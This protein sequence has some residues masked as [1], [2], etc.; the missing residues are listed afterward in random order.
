MSRFR[1][2][3]AP[4]VVGLALLLIWEGFITLFDVDEFLLPRPSSIASALRDQWT[5]LR[6]AGWETGKI[7][8]S[9][10]VI[11]VL[12]GGALALAITRFRGLA[13]SVTPVAVAINA[14]PI[15]A[16]APVFNA[17]FGSTDPRS[18]QAVVVVVVFFP[19]FINTARGLLEV[20]ANQ[21]ELMRSYAA[22]EWTVLR[23]VR[24]PNALP[25]FLTSLRVAA[26]LSVIAAIV[27]EYFGGPQDR[28][29]PF[30]T[31]NAAFSRYANAWA[32]IVVASV[33]GLGLFALA[34]AIERL[35]MPWRR[36]VSGS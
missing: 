9:G 21:L 26:P 3:T 18:N 19:V 14:T 17:W 10:L 29:G 4:V 35:A 30:I 7:A 16:L 11:G 1:K 27:A 20:H 36:P 13:R 34:A 31:Q 15:I 2:L 23:R 22:S 8:A 5:P 24:V 25:Y 12:A 28:L 32:A 33:L 6:T